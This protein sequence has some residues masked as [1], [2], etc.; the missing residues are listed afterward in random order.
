[1]QRIFRD[2]DSQW[3]CAGY[4]DAAERVS[5]LTAAL[6]DRVV[7]TRFVRDPL[8]HGSWKD[9]YD[10]WKR[11]REPEGSS[12]WDLTL[13][14]AEA[15][16]VLSLPTFGKWGAELA[17]LTRNHDRIVVCGVAT[18][19]CVLATVLGAVDAGKH[20][21]VAV[22]ACAG[23]T[24]RAHEQGLELMAMLGPMVTLATTAELVGPMAG[25]TRRAR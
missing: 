22:D 16:A 13:P 2:P 6:A 25:T 7:W 19:C 18:D 4:D 21:T 15:D 24:E 20:V 14:I 11:C 1:M 23:A 12:V 17:E 10:R 8:E 5:E 3:S 9:Y